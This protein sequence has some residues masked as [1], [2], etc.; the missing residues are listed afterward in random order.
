MNHRNIKFISKD[1][2]GFKQNLKEKAGDRVPR[3][4]FKTKRVPYWRP[5]L[6]KRIEDLLVGVHLLPLPKRLRREGL[7]GVHLLPLPKRL[8]REGLV[9]VLL[10]CL[11]KTF[12]REREKKKRERLP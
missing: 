2:S 1:S 3:L 11:I 8:R 12:M 5:P 6:I 4:G 9:G 10:M 7:V